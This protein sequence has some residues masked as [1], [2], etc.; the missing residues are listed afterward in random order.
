MR[1]KWEYLVEPLK[2]DVNKYVPVGDDRGR[3]AFDRSFNSLGSQGWELI[4]IVPFPL[5][6]TVGQIVGVAY[7]KRLRP[8]QP[9]EDEA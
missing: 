3:S 5:N 6:A 7:F 8:K 2:W 1:E 4:Q 9:T